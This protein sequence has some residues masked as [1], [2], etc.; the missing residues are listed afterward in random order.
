M[1]ARGQIT[2]AI[3]SLKIRGKVNEIAD[4][5][6][7]THTIARRYVANPER[8][9]IVSPDNKSRQELNASVR[10]E[11]KANGKLGPE[12]HSFRVLVR[13]D[14]TGAERAWA[15]AV[16]A[17]GCREIFTRQQTDGHRG[18]ELWEDH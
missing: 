1:L 11:L 16:R 14:M 9:L 15:R 6:E 13:Q 12:D 10:K 8:T 17:G 3:G 2:A 5:E 4:P 18:R 7:R